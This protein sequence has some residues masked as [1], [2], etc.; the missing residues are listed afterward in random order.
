MIR[1]H[2]QTLNEEK[3]KKLYPKGRLLVPGNDSFERLL[4]NDSLCYEE[5]L[6]KMK[7]DFLS[8]SRAVQRIL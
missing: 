2:F 1:Q 3:E 7:S 4:D 6:Q 5:S 8:Q